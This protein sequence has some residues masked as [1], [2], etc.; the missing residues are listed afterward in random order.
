MVSVTDKP[1][2]HRRATAQ[3]RVAVGEEIFHKIQRNEIQKGDV[4]S[5]A[6]I[7]GIAAAKRTAELIPLCHNIPLDVVRITHTFNESDHEIVLH[8]TAEATWK[9][10]VEMEALM[11]VSVAALTVYDMCKALSHGIV[12]REVRLL[13]KS[14]GMSSGYDATAE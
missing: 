6:K 9:T 7:A 10:G 12:V 3:A 13:S 2:T 8:A 1:I 11:A 5:T 4:L 14:G